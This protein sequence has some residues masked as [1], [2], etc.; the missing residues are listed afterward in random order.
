MEL[1]P[2]YKKTEVGVIPAEWVCEPLFA[3]FSFISYGFTNPMPTVRDG[4]FMITAADINDG[5]LQLET[6]RRTSKTAYQTLLTAKS[7]PRSNDILLTKDG[8][9]GRLAV[10]GD[11]TICINQSVAVIRPNERVDPQFLK[12]LLESPFYQKRMLEDAGGST[13]KHIYITIVD[14]MPVGLPLDKLEQLAISQAL[15]DVDALLCRLDKLIAKKRDLK[16]AAMQKLLTRETRLPGFSGE[17]E[18]KPLGHAGSCLR[19]VSY[20]GASD[21][22]QYDT[23]DTTRLLRSSNVQQAVVVIDEIQFVNSARVSPDQ[24]LQ[25]NDILICMANGSKALVGKAGVFTIH[26][27]YKYT[28][29]AFM[30]CF[31]TDPKIAHPQFIFHLFQT[32]RYR[33][34]INNILAGSSIN[35]LRPGSVESLEFDFP[36]LREQIAIA[37]VLSDMDAELKALKA[38]RDKTRA[39]KLSMVQELLTGRTRLVSSGGAHA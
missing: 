35:N 3:F 17:W 28:F 23:P 12:M 38:R 21:L 10:V 37:S 9:L 27:S 7:K 2:G 33:D 15:G 16:Q 29:G 1:K 32:G 20:R 19:G 14:K 34:Y 4:V 5:R 18:A 25:S 22:S 26:D 36:K 31:R 39:L 30:S 6:A 8:T 24:I 11:E 13:I